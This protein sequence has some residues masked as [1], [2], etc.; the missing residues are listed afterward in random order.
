MPAA[1]GPTALY[2]PSH[3]SRRTPKDLVL[4]NDRK[5]WRRQT[6]WRAARAILM[7]PKSR[8]RVANRFLASLPPLIQYNQSVRLSWGSGRHSRCTIASVRRLADGG[9]FLHWI[10]V[11]VS[12]LVFSWEGETFLMPSM[13]V[14]KSSVRRI[15]GDHRIG[16][17]FT[18]HAA[19]AETATYTWNGSAGATWDITSNNWNLPSSGASA[20]PWN[21]MSGPA[22]LRRTSLH[23]QRQP[24]CRAAFSLM[25]LSLRLPPT[26]ARSPG[27]RLTRPRVRLAVAV[28]RTAAQVRRLA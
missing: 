4:R 23:R 27:E 21:S 8:S 24:T 20:N 22:E 25:P 6:F 28:P 9:S 1:I 10:V 2:A 15:L 14:W 3:R 11:L 19:T 13:R 17:L 26:T 7:P 5:C 12:R 16:H 18:R